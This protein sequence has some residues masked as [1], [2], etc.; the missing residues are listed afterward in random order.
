MKGRIA[1]CAATVAAGTLVLAAGTAGAHPMDNNVTDD[2]WINSGKT[3]HWNSHGAAGAEAG[4]Q[5]VL[6]REEGLDLV[7]RFDLGG[8]L[9]GEGRV[10]HVSGQGHKTKKKIL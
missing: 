1:A 5:T 3:V 6:P 4:R 2:S 10:A 7:G 9:G 8:K